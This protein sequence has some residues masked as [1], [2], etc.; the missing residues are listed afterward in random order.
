MPRTPAPPDDDFRPREHPFDD[1]IAFQHKEWKVERVGWSLLL[2]L[3][4]LA[5]MGLFA[6]GLL[7]ERTETSADGALQL[8]YPRFMRKGARSTMQITLQGQPRASLQVTLEAP[9]LHAHNV[10]I[11]QPYPPISSSEQGGLRLTVLADQAGRASIHLTVRAERVGPTHLGVRFGEH[12]F[13]L[14]QFI[15]P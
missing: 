2:T 13:W 1:E 6:E 15:Y 4:L 12:H 14:W 10:E 5:G 7:S 8:E 3:V 11:I 9:F